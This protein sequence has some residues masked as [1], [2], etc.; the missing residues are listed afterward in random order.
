[1]GRN[2]AIPIACVLVLLT[3]ACSSKTPSLGP[4]PTAQPTGGAGPSTISSPTASSSPTSVTGGTGT[5]ING[6]GSPIPTTSP[7]VTGSVTQGAATL[8]VTGGLE[9]TQP[10]L[11][12]ASP[13]VYAPPPGGFALNWS[14]GAAGF[15]MSGTSF[16]GAHPTSVALHLTFFV[17]A[18]SG[19]RT[20]SSNAGE[21]QVTVSQADANAFI[22]A[23][24]CASLSDASGGSPV[25]A[26]GTF[27][28]TG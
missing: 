25:T 11:L 10:G 14:S 18:S 16:V 24:S 17:H 8:T 2:L 15:A 13:A 3:A 1:M 20:F 21:C 23:F 27:A 22:G 9:T 4:P 6:S 5:T 12:L 7:G 28:A 26:Q 19:T